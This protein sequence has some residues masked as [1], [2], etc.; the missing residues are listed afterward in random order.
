M[1]EKAGKARKTLA[2][3]KFH[4]P[5]ISHGTAIIREFLLT[6]WRETV[7]RKSMGKISGTSTMGTI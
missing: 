1:Q 5:T 7:R 3:I 2:Q 6:I 4:V